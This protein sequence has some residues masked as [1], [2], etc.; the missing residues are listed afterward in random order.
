MRPP[1]FVDGYDLRGSLERFVI[2]NIF[3][4]D[5]NSLSKTLLISVTP[6]F[7]D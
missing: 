1:F 4:I 5:G 6:S 2:V 7:I 3:Y